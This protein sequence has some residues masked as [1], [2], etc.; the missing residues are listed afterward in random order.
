MLPQKNLKFWAHFLAIWYIFHHKIRE[1][2]QVL[3][4][5]LLCSACT[6]DDQ[7]SLS[8]HE[9]LGHTDNIE[10]LLFWGHWERVNEQ[11][12]TGVLGA[13][14]INDGIIIQ[15]N[16]FVDVHEESIQ[17]VLLH[18]WSQHWLYI[19]QFH[20]RICLLHSST[21]DWDQQYS[22]YNTRWIFGNMRGNVPPIVSCK[23]WGFEGEH[24]H[25]FFQTLASAAKEAG[26]GRPS[27]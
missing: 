25:F 4:A 20:C 17:S 26:E 16:V 14:F 11:H 7:V 9:H 12:S 2:G 22:R 5:C 3:Y 8:V 1:H 15:V 23:L 18:C 13:A 10:G 27:P 21:C 19:D 6:V 24:A